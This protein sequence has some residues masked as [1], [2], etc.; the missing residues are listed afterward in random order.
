M[1]SLKAKAEVIVT[2][3]DIRRTS[4]GHLASFLRIQLERVLNSLGEGWFTVDWRKKYIFSKTPCT[5]RMKV[6]S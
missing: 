2:T 3:A 6:A 4:G 1:A 5:F